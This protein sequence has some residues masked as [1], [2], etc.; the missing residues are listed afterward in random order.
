MVVVQ[1]PATTIGTIRIRELDPKTL[2]G[3]E[4]TFPFIT[5]ES[6]QYCLAV[7]PTDLSA[8]NEILLH[9]KDADGLTHCIGKEMATPSGP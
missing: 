9:W 8:K 7:K 1:L 4:N 3:K 6:G 5:D 2:P